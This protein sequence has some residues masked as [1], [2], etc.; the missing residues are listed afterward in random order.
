MGCKIEGVMPTAFELHSN[1]PSL[2]F[3]TSVLNM[4]GVPKNIVHRTL[5][6]ECSSIRQS[7]ERV[8]YFDA[9]A[10]AYYEEGPCD[11]KETFKRLIYS[12]PKW[13]LILMKVRDFVMAFAGFKTSSGVQRAAVATHDFSLKIGQR[14][15]IFQIFDISTN[16]IIFGENDRHLDFRVSLNGEDEV[17]KKTVS[18]ITVVKFNNYFGRTYF[19]LVRPFHKFVVTAML[20]NVVAQKESKS[21]DI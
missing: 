5:I 3:T 10:V 11:V 20:S 7:L 8:D 12:A 17:G 6:P 9:F 18:L 16:E 2:S 15:G 1:C 4:R 21:I 19:F 13:V 14:F